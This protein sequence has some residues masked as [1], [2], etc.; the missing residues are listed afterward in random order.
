MKFHI[1]PKKFESGA[2][3]SWII[4]MMQ[5]S[6]VRGP[7][8]IFVPKFITNLEFVISTLLLWFISPVCFYEIQYH[9]YQRTLLAFTSSC[10]TLRFFALWTCDAS[11]AMTLIFHRLYQFTLDLSSVLSVLRETQN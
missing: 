2:K 9:R 11:I 5:L 8:V 4:V 10:F 1:F 6:I 7:E 3:I